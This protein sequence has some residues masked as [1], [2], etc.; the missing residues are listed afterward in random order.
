MTAFSTS[1]AP[2]SRVQSAQPPVRLAA[3][4][5]ILVVAT[6]A[7]APIVLGAAIN[8]P[9]SLDYPASQMLPLLIQ[10][11]AAILIGY[12]GYLLSSI[13][14]IPM[15]LLLWQALDPERQSATL[16]I[17]TTFGV[18]AGVA[19]PLGILRWFVAMPALAQSYVDAN[20]TDTTR[21]A[22]TVAYDTLN[23][24]AGTLGELLGV[25]LLG[26]MWALLLGFG[27]LRQRRML[28][29]GWLGIFV[30][31]LSLLPLGQVYGLDFGPIL[32]ASNVA[33]YLWVLAFGIRLLVAR[34]AAAR[35]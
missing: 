5:M 4:L 30:G 28:L 10:Q 29:F 25:A 33:W 20:T 16:Q 35:S 1:A 15:A 14:I 19:K 2:M 7:V 13:L 24:Y 21:Q 27:L 11:Q 3:V 23:A 6:F 12:S 31:V 9:A 18:L 8:W 17:A 32:V 22:I 26:G 34:P